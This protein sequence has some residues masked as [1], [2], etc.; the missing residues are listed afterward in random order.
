[1]AYKYPVVNVRIAADLLNEVRALPLKELKTTTK[2][3]DY[4]IK[5]GMKHAR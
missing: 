1:M 3:V 5:I 2:K 4:L